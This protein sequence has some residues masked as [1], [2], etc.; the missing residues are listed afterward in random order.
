MR[1]PKLQLHVFEE[2]LNQIPDNHGYVDIGYRTKYMK[3]YQKKLTRFVMIQIG[4]YDIKLVVMLWD[5][6]N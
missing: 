6:N 2:I 3:I 1:L 5:R 4:N